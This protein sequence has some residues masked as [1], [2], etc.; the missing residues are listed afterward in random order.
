MIGGMDRFNILGEGTN[1][2]ITKEVQ[3]L[4]DGFGKDGGYILSL[5][6]HFFETPV[7]NLN[8]LPPKNCTN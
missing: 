6:D 2:Q 8:G 3:R 7:E 1:E 5:S 4:F